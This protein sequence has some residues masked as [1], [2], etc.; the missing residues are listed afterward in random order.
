MHHDTRWLARLGI[1]QGLFTRPQCLE[2][3]AKLGDDPKNPSIIKTVRG[4][5]Y[6]LARDGLALAHLV[7]P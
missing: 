5:G 4:V 7:V 6:V 2:V 1:D 3:Q